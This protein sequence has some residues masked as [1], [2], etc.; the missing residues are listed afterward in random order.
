MDG[1]TPAFFLHLFIAIASG[2]VA[3]GAIRQDLRHIHEQIAAL[4]EL[5]ADGK[6]LREAL[7]RETT[8]SVREIME[9]M[10]SVHG[11]I[12]RIEGYREGSKD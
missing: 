10:E 7:A 9:K 3:Y 8:T 5:I 2:G 4:S 12:A 6:R 11:R 1:F